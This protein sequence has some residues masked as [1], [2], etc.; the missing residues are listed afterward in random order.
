MHP[1]TDHL[2]RRCSKPVGHGH[3]DRPTEDAVRDAGLV[4]VPLVSDLPLRNLRRRWLL[5]LVIRRNHR[6]LIKKRKKEKELRR[7]E[8]RPE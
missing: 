2:D 7:K 6:Q 5:P 4:G 1:G 3:C 8:K